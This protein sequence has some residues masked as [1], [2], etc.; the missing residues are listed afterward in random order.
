VLPTTC[1]PVSMRCQQRA[2]AAV[3]PVAGDLDKI[4]RASSSAAYE[5]AKLWKRSRERLAIQWTVRTRWQTFTARSA[6]PRPRWRAKAS[7]SAATL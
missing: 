5:V 3:F 7:A 1:V 2:A 4:K 6:M